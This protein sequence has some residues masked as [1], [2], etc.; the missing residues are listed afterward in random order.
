MIEIDEELT[1]VSRTYLP[2]WS[3]CSDVAAGGGD[4]RIT[5]SRFD[6]PKTTVRF[7]DAFGYFLR[8][9]GGDEDEVDGE[10]DNEDELFDVIIMD[11]LDPDD[12]GDFVD[13][14]HNDTAF[15]E[16]LYDG[17]AENGVF[18]VQLGSSPER[19]NPPDESSHFYNGANM[20][21]ELEN[22]CFENIHAYNE[23]HCHFYTLWQLMV[24]FKDGAQSRL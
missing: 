15:I 10:E 21:R 16:S 4:E 17:L 14:L 6:D 19:A 3:D 11:T 1:N 5:A 20:L 22:A 12:F 23:S 2:E 13:V 8:N 18:V 7:E 24:A 9:F